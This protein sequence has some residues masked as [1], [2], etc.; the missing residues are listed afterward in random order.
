MLPLQAKDQNEDVSE[1]DRSK[2]PT[3]I[4]A[5]LGVL[6]SALVPVAMSLGLIRQLQASVTL[7]MLF[8]IGALLLL[9]ALLF[10]LSVRQRH[11]E[12]IYLRAW[13]ERRER[14]LAL[15]HQRQMQAL[16]RSVRESRR[17]AQPDQAEWESEDEQPLS[18]EARLLRSLRVEPSP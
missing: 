13:K 4:Y 14:Q 10:A 12:R 7:E 2:T 5:F 18:M 3:R 16:E 17:R 6:A 11:N 15:K 8:S 1:P 9:V